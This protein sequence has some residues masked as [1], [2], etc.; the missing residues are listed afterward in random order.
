VAVTLYST[1]T[2]YTSN[3]LTFLRGSQANVTGVG[4][5]HS[6]NPNIVPT[7]AEF[8]TVTLADGTTIPPNP[9]AIPGE[10]DVV[11]LV[12]PGGQVTGL[13]TGDWQRFVLVQT[14]NENIIRAVDVI[15]IL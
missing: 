4:V 12:G 3:A 13:T 10:I 15:T 1:A 9:L 14:I 2:E 11:A 6:L 8:T 7:V 5:Y